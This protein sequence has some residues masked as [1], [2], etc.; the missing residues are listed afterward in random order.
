MTF[1]PL[2][3]AS[4]SGLIFRRNLCW[5]SVFTGGSAD[6]S[7]TTEACTSAITVCD[8]LTHC[9]GFSYGFDKAAAANPV[10]GIY[11]ASPILNGTGA[12]GLFGRACSASNNGLPQP[13]DYSWEPFLTE[14]YR[15]H[16][17]H[18]SS[19]GVL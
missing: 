14:I 3:G 18:C 17:S 8:I 10:D 15:A 12:S 9:A 7:Y 1:T 2:Y 11:N 19:G 5:Q 4:S 13:L 16:P 6:Q